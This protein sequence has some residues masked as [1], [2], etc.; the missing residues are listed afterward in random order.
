MKAIEVMNELF[1]WAPGDHGRTC[2]ERK[3]GSED[4]EVS[5][6]AVCCFP[7]PQVIRDAAAWGAQLLITHEPLYHDHWDGEPDTP[8]GKAKKALIEQT[9]LTIYRY[10]DHPHSAPMDLICEGELK[11]LGLGGRLTGRSEHGNYQYTLDEP[12]T[13][14]ELAARVEKAFGIAHVRI[15][16]V[17]DEPCSRLALCWGA[18]WGVFDEM[19]GDAEIVLAGETCE[20][21][22]GEYARNAAQLGMR[23]ALLILGHCGSETD[24]M[25]HVAGIMQEKLPQLEIRYFESGEVYTYPDSD[26]R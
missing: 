11:A 5:R 24:G 25:K 22:V 3:A 21:Q 17:T 26:A 9:G 16:G 2:D 10:H 7:S 6:V 4:A 15:C 20:W 8:V 19:V 18:P 14:R 1:S 13:P 12:I 23:K